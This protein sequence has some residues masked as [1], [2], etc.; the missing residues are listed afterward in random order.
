MRRLLHATTVTA[1]L[2][3]LPAMAH[4]HDAPKV[5]ASI[6]PLNAIATAV[7]DGVG[8]PTVLLPPGTSPH[9]AALRPSQ[10]Q[11]LEDADVVFWIGPTLETFLERPLDSLAAGADAAPLITT[12]GIALLKVREGDGFEAHDHSHGDGHDDHGHDDHAHDD[13]GHDHGHDHAHDDHGHDD[14]HDHGHDHANDDH[15]HDQGHEH[16][17]DDHDHGH[18]HAHDDHAHD[19][20]G[21]DGQR[22]DLWE[23]DAH[24]W[25][26]PRN[27]VAI[28]TAMAARLAAIDPAHASLYRANAEAFATRMSAVEAEIDALLAPVRDRRFIVFHDAYQYFEA[29][30]GMAAAG[31]ITLSPETPPGAARI[32][33]IRETV[34]SAGAVCAFSEPQFSAAIVASVLD[35]TDAGTA[36][37]DPIGTGGPGGY[38]AM[39]RA[40][41]EAV[42]TCLGAAS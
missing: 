9:H 7:M 3:A 4:A 5:V 30:F 40:N 21:H 6:Q 25:L 33:E 2:T 13:H 28:A 38:E 17:H 27:G 12:A 22:G 35:G 41:A 26:D 23:M 19:G 42:A 20:H 15:G 18:D 1:A 37:M 34:T 24:I 31:A 36:V 39:L 8:D 16:A 11:A 14:G 10:A 32:A 29:R